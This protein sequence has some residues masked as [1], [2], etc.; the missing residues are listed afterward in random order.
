MRRR[1]RSGRTGSRAGSPLAASSIGAVNSPTEGPGSAGRSGSRQ[2]TEEAFGRIQKHRLTSVHTHARSLG[3]GI[4]P[5][6]GEQHA[7]EAAVRAPIHEVAT[8]PLRHLDSSLT[9]QAISRD[10]AP[11]EQGSE[12]RTVV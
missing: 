7:L 2:A 5:P 1:R 11:A 8:A 3:R 10:P 6:N 9:Y 12:S 4:A